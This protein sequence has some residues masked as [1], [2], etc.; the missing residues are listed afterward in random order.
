MN[1]SKNKNWWN[2][3]PMTYLDWDLKKKDRIVKQR[4]GFKELNN[5]YLDTNPFLKKKFKRLNKK[6][7]LQD[8]VTLDLG[9]GWGTSS[10]NLAKYSKKL[11]AIDISEMSIKGARENFRFNSKKKINLKKMDAEKLRFKKNF[12]DYVYSWGVIHHSANPEKIFTNIY[13]VLKKG[14]K[15]FI[16]IY[17]KHS[18]RYYCLGLYFLI[19]KLKIL[20]GYNL[21][22]VQKFFTDG[23]YHKHY[24]KKE[25]TNI[26]SKIGF[27]NIKIDIDYMAARVFPGV[28]KNSKLD[29]YLKKR[30]GW[31]LIV[32]FNK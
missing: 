18:L 28:K 2:K 6:N 31:F 26:L 13:K 24:T 30:F 11:Y 10:I 15:S 9:C 16:M 23:F 1:N 32:S 12:F 29:L 5:K 14:G 27:K 20:A 8:K 7:F 19:A 17:N 22:T 21:D 25:I 3:N 4:D